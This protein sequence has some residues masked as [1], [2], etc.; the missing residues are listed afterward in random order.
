MLAGIESRFTA[1]MAAFG[2]FE[3][4]PHLAVALSG[5][6]DSSALAMLTHAWARSRGGRI[7]ALTVDHGLRPES[8]GEAARVGDWARARGFD[9][10]VLEW[11]GS[12]PARRIQERAR[13]ARHGLLAAW[14]LQAGVLHLCLGHNAD[15]QDETVA[16]RRA[17]RSRAEGLAG[18]AM[19]VERRDVR[20]LR[21]LLGT[22]R[23][24]IEAWLRARGATWIEDPSNG[25][26]RFLRARMRRAGE[27][28]V[29]ATGAAER[30]A[31]A[32]VAIAGLAARAGQFGPGRRVFLDRSSLLIADPA[33]ARGLIQRAL[34]AIGRKR[35]IREPALEAFCAWVRD[36]ADV[37]SRTLGG[38]LAIIRGQGLHVVPEGSVPAAGVV[39]GTSRFQAL[40]VRHAGA[41][42]YSGRASAPLDSVRPL[43]PV[44][45]PAQP[46]GRARFFDPFAATVAG[47]LPSTPSSSAPEPASR[48][49]ALENSEAP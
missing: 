1:S 9:H 3:P 43:E 11:C 29:A 19:L 16:M 12:K 30:R 4:R 38:C 47:P 14:C 31:A 39:E 23:L 45:R 40:D 22:R 33:A 46:I 17:K 32:D 6:A 49:E 27:I 41:E 7:T 28:P 25:D 15:D 24:E 44:P 10:V 34:L 18:I 48:P 13:D 8:A 21:P 2:P 35:A 42:V 36:P 37:V 20:L 26:L 5:G